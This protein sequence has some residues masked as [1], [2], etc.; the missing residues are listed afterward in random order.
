M[1]GILLLFGINKNIAM[2]ITILDR[3]ISYWSIIPLGYLTFILSK[4]T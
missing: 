3:L 4:R 2:S 1:V